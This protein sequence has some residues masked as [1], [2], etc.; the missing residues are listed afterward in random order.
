VK[1]EVAHFQLLDGRARAVVVI[2][3]GITR[4]AVQKHGLD[5]LAAIALGRSMACVAA[6]ASTLKHSQQ[7]VNISFDGN[8]P[9]GKVWAECNGSGHCRGYTEVK[10]LLSVLTKDDEIPQTVSQ[11]LGRVGLLTVTKGRFGEPEPYRSIIDWADGEIASDI[12]RYLS[13]SD[14]IPSAVAA[15]V[16]INKDG[17]VLG[18]GA[19]LVQ[20]LGGSKIEDNELSELE[21]KMR[22]LNISDRI[23]R[24]DSV[25]DI[26]KYVSGDDPTAVLLNRKS[27]EFLC[28][29]SREKMANALHA[30]GREELVS[31]EKDVGK[32]ESNCPYCSERQLFTLEELIPH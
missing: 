1:N 3:T 2:S 5:P 27:L 12:A 17:E 16:K 9:L 19:A 25:E 4:S 30:L 22:N 18:S 10:Q 7:Y 14:Q 23:A 15:G 21:S 29:C 20:Q 24:G 11:A 8:G 31:I 26:F 13:E 32:I 6:L 28:S